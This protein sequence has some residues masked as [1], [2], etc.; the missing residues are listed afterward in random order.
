MV[1]R[2]DPTDRIPLD[3]LYEIE[4]FFKFDLVEAEEYLAK[5][6]KFQRHR[7][8]FK[9]GFDPLK[10]AQDDVNTSKKN[11]IVVNEAITRAKKLRL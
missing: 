1:W 10:I 5:V 11:L 6:I 8:Q 2:L 9:G 4:K 3:Q 7:R